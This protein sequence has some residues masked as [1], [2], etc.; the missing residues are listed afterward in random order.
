MG[1]RG[2]GGGGRGAPD[3]SRAG[4]EDFSWGERGEEGRGRKG[5]ERK[6][7]TFLRTV[8]KVSGSSALKTKVPK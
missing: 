5:E 7:E 4:R 2:G 8:A 3:M 6:R 1:G